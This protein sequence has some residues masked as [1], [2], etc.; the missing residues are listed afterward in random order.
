MTVNE[1]LKAHPWM[2]KLPPGEEIMEWC[3]CCEA[4]I[5]EPHLDDCNV[6]ECTICHD[7]RLESCECG[8]IESFPPLFIGVL[9]RHYTQ[10]ALEHGLYSRCMVKGKNGKWRGCDVSEAKKARQKGLPARSWRKCKV[11]D[12]HAVPDVD[13]ARRFEAQARRN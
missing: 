9:D 5:G 13:G 12:A 1:I 3:P 6:A 2:R 7:W 11:T 8:G 10:I 4:P